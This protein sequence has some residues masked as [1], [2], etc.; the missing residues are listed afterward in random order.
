MM[1]E[2]S[3][4]YTKIELKRLGFKKI[5][6]NIKIS[7]KSSI[8]FPKD[9]IIGDNSRVDDFVVISGKVKIGKN[10]HLAPH[11]IVCGG[12]KAIIFKDFSGMAFGSKV[13]G[14]SDDYSGS[15]MT[16]PTVNKDYK[17]KKETSI[18]IGKH[19]IIGANSIILPGGSI[20]D[21]SAL[22]SMSM[23]TKKVKK[24]EIYFGI[25]AKKLKDRSKK[26]LNIYNKYKKIYEKK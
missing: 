13:I 8:Y 11:T 10:V 18:I 25:P 16:N 24:F 9:M 26:I 6:R 17:K 1:I 15:S 12:N 3:N 2:K 5:G 4:Y 22:G 14:V 19:S 23:L 20:D 21:F 7:K